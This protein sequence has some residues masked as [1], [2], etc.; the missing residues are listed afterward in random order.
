MYTYGAFKGALILLYLLPYM[1]ER[2]KSTKATKR[3]DM[4]RKT[5]ADINRVLDNR[6]SIFLV[7][8]K[9]CQSPIFR[10]WLVLCL[11]L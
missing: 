7:W 4:L 1:I 9:S 11:C 2:Y 5:H 3:S 6:K 8:Y 10:V